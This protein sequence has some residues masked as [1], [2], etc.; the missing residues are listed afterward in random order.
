MIFVN[1]LDNKTKIQAPSVLHQ[2]L[3]LNHNK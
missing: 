2:D 1:K 3:N